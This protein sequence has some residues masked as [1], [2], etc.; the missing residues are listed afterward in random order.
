MLGRFKDI[1]SSKETVQDII[2][3]EVAKTKRVGPQAE[4]TVWS[5]GAAESSFEGADDEDGN[6]LDF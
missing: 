3:S 1:L 5:S 6:I 2:S 4:A